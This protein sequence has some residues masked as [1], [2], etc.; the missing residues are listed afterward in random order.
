MVKSMKDVTSN[1]S[2]PISDLSY[3]FYSN[4][5]KNWDDNLDYFEMQLDKTS[6]TLKETIEML[7]KLDRGI[8]SGKYRIV[9]MK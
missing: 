5:V 6:Y 1:F 2:K 9:E 7:A 3:D 8:K 4:F